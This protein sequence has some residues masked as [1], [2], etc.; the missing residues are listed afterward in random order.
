M[1]H[2]AEHRGRGHLDVGIEDLCRADGALAE[3]QYLA[4]LDAWCA[5]IDEEI[6]D[7]LLLP[8]PG[9]SARD[10]QAVVADVHA[11]GEHLLPVDNVSAVGGRGPGRQ[12]S[13]V[14]AR[15]GLGQLHGPGPLAGMHA[16]RT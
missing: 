2:R 4:D 1:V 6:R 9:G 14:G 16:S 3:S 12:C 13:S 10:Q 15:L 5:G 11:G 8:R 7:A